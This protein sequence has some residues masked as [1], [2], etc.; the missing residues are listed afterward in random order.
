MPAAPQVSIVV[1]V[2]NESGNIRALWQAVCEH[3][4]LRY[5]DF[6]LILVDDGSTDDTLA[7]VRALR[8]E[9]PR[10]KGVSLSRNFGHQAAVS[11]GMFYAQGAA[12]IV[13]DG[14]LQ[15]PPELLPEMLA[16]WEDGFDV[17]QTVRISTQDISWLKSVTSRAFYAVMNRL[18]DIPL[19]AG[20][21]DF[22]LMDRKVVDC[23]NGLQESNR[24]LRGLVAW[25]G[26]R[27]TTVSYHASPRHW[28]R[29]HYNWRR[30]F[31]FAL[32]G[33][34]SFSTLPLRLSTY[35]GFAAAL[36]GI[37]YLI[38]AIYLR[39]F[40]EEA[41]TGWAS[42]IVAVLFLGGVQLIC[43]G[44]LGEYVGR[45]YEEIKRRPLFIPQELIGLKQ[46]LQPRRQTTE[47]SRS[48]SSISDEPEETAS[49]RGH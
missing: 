28:G 46:P 2:L 22:R 29:T 47:F 48:Q 9:D 32:D 8:H 15:H 16:A 36:L 19:T 31:S 14:D 3:L 21:A 37:P 13:M 7:E 10:V 35:L 38:W 17:V 49:S 34:T 27:Q 26:F 33:I 23:L 6:E 12:V 42:I 40:T 24:F 25:V 44:I 4:E 43:M 41:E 45:I 20:S 30:M 18:A 1:P 5:P 39:V 11:A